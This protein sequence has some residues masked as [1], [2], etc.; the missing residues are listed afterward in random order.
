MIGGYLLAFSL[1]M[2][3][4]KW[5]TVLSIG[6]LKPLLLLRTKWATLNIT[7]NVFKLALEEEVLSSITTKIQVVSTEVKRV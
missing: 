4:F 3:S 1:V 2:S 7:G 6:H 5:S